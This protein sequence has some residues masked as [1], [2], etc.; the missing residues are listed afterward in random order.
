[1]RGLESKLLT[2]GLN[3]LHRS[4]IHPRDR[5]LQSWLILEISFVVGETD[6]TACTSQGSSSATTSPIVV[7]IL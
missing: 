3:L 2:N 7:L 6:T 1:M 4:I 5:N